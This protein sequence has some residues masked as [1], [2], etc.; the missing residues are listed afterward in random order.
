[1][2]G[3]IVHAVVCVLKGLRPVGRRIDG[4]E[5]F[6]LALAAA[7][8]PVPPVLLGSGPSRRIALRARD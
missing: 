4:A 3:A 1:M 6:L 5:T 2:R 7:A 8:L